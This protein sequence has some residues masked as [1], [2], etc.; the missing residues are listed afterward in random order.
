MAK[1]FLGF[2]I[3]GLTAATLVMA[4]D[5]PKPKPKP[6]PAAKAAT[7]EKAAMEAMMKAATPGENH[8]KLEAFVGTFDVK[9]KMWEKPGAAPQESAGTSE[10]KMVLG[11]RYVHEDFQGTF[12]GQ[13]FTGMGMTGY[14]NVQNKFVSTWADTM[15][16]GIMTSTGKANASGN[17]MDMSASMADPVT[18]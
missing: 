3:T 8:K 5:N 14:D 4:A 10:G 2:L 7:D 15:S 1:R 17:G 11:G 12:M 6:M 18:G 9:V 13:P 16:T